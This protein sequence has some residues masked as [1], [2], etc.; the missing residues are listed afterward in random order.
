MAKR[1]KPRFKSTSIERKVAKWLT[2]SNIYYKPQFRVGYF[3][4]DFYIPKGNL[5]IQ[6]DGCY[7]HFNHCSCNVGKVP[8]AK[9]NAQHFRDKSCNGVLLSRGH[10]VL[11]LWE[12]DINNDWEGCTQK[13]LKALEG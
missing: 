13:I 5:I 11:R 7:W 9:Q 12:C 1:R 2:N 10:K 4:V 6:T 8:T 3:S